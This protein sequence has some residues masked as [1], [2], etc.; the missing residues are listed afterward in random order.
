VCG[1]VLVSKQSVFAEAKGTIR[2]LSEPFSPHIQDGTCMRWFAAAAASK[3]TA[4]VT[5]LTSGLIS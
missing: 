2:D 4:V 5:A 1:T 3:H